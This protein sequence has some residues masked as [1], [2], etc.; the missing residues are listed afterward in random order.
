M[1]AE[2]KRQ[3]AALPDYGAD[4]GAWRDW[5]TAA[6]RPAFGRV[7]DFIRHGRQRIDG[8]AVVVVEGTERVEFKIAEQRDLLAGNLRA[9][10][11]SVS[12]GALRVPALSRTEQED[13][14]IALV[15]L[16][17]VTAE[18]STEE[19]TRDWL[20]QAE[21]AASPIRGSLAP[22]ER[23]AALEQIL[24]HG[25]FTRER[26][27]AHTDPRSYTDPGDR[28]RPVLLQEIA[29]VDDKPTVAARW[30]RVG[31]VAMFLRYCT[32]APP[33]SHLTLDGRI[34]AAGG[35][36]CR[37]AARSRAT[38]RFLTAKLY[39]LPDPEPDP[40]DTTD[41]GQDAAR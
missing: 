24:G 40:P 25:T 15:T 16:A 13:I 37:L 3:L 11:A 36:R 38:R 28:P 22:G 41:D 4:L 29:L 23:Y 10:L 39:R 17:T 33:M 1:M 21:D 12:D 26:A 34:E 32:L 31:D 8:C 27:L 7:E 14:W 19:E 9:T 5:L 35:E 2:S 30:M 6:I 18:Q 20:E